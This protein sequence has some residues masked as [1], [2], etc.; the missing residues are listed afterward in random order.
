ML[1]MLLWLL[2]N[3]PKCKLNCRVFGSP[4]TCPLNSISWSNG[5]DVPLMI[6]IR[7]GSGLEL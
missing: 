3:G 1:N 2:K 5:V 7:L 4:K 6:G